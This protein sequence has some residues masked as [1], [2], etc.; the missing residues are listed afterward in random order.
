M[1]MN[2]SLALPAAVTTY[3]RA[4]HVIHLR[5]SAPSN[6]LFTAFS[7]LALSFSQIAEFNLYVKLTYFTTTFPIE[8]PPLSLLW[9]F[10]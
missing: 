4:D 9:S 2:P 1:D 6:A 3:C 5:K 7:V 10:I 8:A